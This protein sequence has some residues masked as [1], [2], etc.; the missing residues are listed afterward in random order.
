LVTLPH[1][2]AGEMAYDP[3]LARSRYTAKQVRLLQTE[4]LQAQHYRE[5]KRLTDNTKDGHADKQA[6][7]AY[8]LAA[9]AR[10]RL[11]KKE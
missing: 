8:I 5:K 2:K 3:A 10:A 4:Q 7:N 11:G 6:K 9:M 1:L